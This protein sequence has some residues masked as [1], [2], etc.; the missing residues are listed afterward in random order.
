MLPNQVR[1]CYL[2]L[3]IY[4]QERLRDDEM[5]ANKSF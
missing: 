5:K 3:Y 4:N 2:Y 1:V